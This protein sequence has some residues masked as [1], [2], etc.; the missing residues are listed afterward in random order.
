[1]NPFLLKLRSKRNILSLCLILRNMT[2]CLLIVWI[3]LIIH[4]SNIL[5]MTHQ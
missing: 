5:W 2:M 4:P 1:M 3:I